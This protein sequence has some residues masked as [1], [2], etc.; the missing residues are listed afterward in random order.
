MNEMLVAEGQPI[1][2]EYDDIQDMLYVT[3]SPSVGSTYYRDVE[4]LPGVM[5]RYDAETD[6][7]VGITVHNVKR[8]M[9]RWFVEELYERL[10]TPR[11]REVLVPA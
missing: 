10:V 9:Q 1:Y 7:V 2:Y 8:K 3:F 11:K 5:L 6:R 4:G